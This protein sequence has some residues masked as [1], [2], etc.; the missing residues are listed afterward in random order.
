MKFETRLAVIAVGPLVAV[1]VILLG[2]R[3][4]QLLEANA[5]AS[6]RSG[7]H[8]LA[9]ITVL[10]LANF[11]VAWRFAQ[12]WPITATRL[13]IWAVIA[14]LGISHLIDLLGNNST[15]AWRALGVGNPDGTPGRILEL[16]ARIATWGI[17]LFMSIVC[18]AVGFESTRG[19][20]E[21]E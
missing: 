9:V 11:L 3:S 18:V 10:Y 14:Y 16:R 15:L 5:A 12:S 2:E 21:K 1:A 4:A 7:H 19:E 20:H 17:I 13:L 6:L 8:W